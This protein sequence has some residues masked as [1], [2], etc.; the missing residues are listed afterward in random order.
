L[1]SGKSPTARAGGYPKDGIFQFCY[2]HVMGIETIFL[3]FGVIV[4]IAIYA[5]F[6]KTKDV[7]TA[8]TSRANIQKRGKN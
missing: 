7:G 2:R 4:T 3:A 1:V 5:G 8:N 6:K